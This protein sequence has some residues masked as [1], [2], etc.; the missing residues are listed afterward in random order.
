MNIPFK[1]TMVW[2]VMAIISS[3]AL[4]NFIIML[5]LIGVS[6]DFLGISKL[7]SSLS[8]LLST[9]KNASQ[10]VANNYFLIIMVIFPLSYV[11]FV[12]VIK[13]FS[14][15]KYAN[16]II[17]FYHNHRKVI[18][19]Y[20]TVVLVFFGFLPIFLNI[21]SLQQTEFQELNNIF[22]LVSLGSIFPYFNLLI[23]EAKEKT[24]LDNSLDKSVDYKEKNKVVKKKDDVY[25]LLN[26]MFLILIF[27]MIYYMYQEKFEFSEGTSIDLKTILTVLGTILGAYFGAKVA[28][29][30][31]IESVERQIANSEKRESKNDHRRLI[32]SLVLYRARSLK[33]LTFLNG[34]EEVV[35]KRKILSGG[36]IGLQQDRDLLLPIKKFLAKELE[37]LE[38][39]DISQIYSENFYV[40]TLILEN[41]DTLLNSVEEIIEA[42]KNMDE[43]SLHAYRGFYFNTIHEFE[44]NVEHINNKLSSLK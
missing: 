9:N 44:Q 22:L 43:E 11:S 3:I 20:F 29:K 31:A 15:V 1:T 26:I 6:L 34:V 40:F 12:Y 41:V 27:I 32:Q 24:I 38:R 25:F 8:I 19:A 16:E 5:Y 7:L 23:A 33:I 28:G 18:A 14:K 13:G 36:V 21:L 4:L 10:V 2:S 35:N 42:M 39:I 37:Q 30:Y 17:A